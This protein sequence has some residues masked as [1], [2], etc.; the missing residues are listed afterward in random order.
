M[1]EYIG[2]KGEAFLEV[3]R[4]WRFQRIFSRRAWSIYVFCAFSW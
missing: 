1:P 3:D 4:V 2:L